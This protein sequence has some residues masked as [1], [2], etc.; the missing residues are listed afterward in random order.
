MSLRPMDT[1][2]KRLMTPSISLLV[3]AALTPEEHEV[4]IIDENIQEISHYDNAD[5]VGITCNVDTFERAKAHSIQF[6]NNGIPVILGGIFPSS[7]PEMAGQYADS[8]CI[9]DAEPL[10]Q[11][12]LNDAKRGELKKEYKWHN[13]YPAAMIPRPKW[14]AIEKEKYLYTNVITTSRGCPFSCEFCYNSC[15][16]MEKKYR[17][18]P[19]DSIIGEIIALG[20]SQVLF[21]DDNFI[22]DKQW[23]QDFL[24]RIKPLR[25]TWHAAV[26]ADI[27]NHLSILDSMK[28][29]GC[30]SLYIGFES[31]NSDSLAN[32]KKTQNLVHDYE[33]T[34][35]SIHS[36]DMMINAS[37]AF[38]FD[39]DYPDV[40][41]NSL[42][43]L[44]RNRIETMTSH[45]LT[46]YPGT[47]LYQRLANEGRI[48]D[49]NLN[50]YNTSKVVFATKNMTPEQLLNG[51]H[52][53]Y[54]DFYSVQ[55]ILKRRPKSNKQWVPYFL[56][57][58]GYRKY[59]KLTARIGTMGHMQ[60]I[61]KLARKL[62]YGIG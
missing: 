39:C 3:L 26:S 29:T 59:G 34:I 1:E 6:Q 58:L 21:V 22:G 23:L 14:E 25:L 19:L 61:G 36:R 11:T 28:E 18:R 45:I 57:N 42:E 52:K 17:R 47:K 4:E 55:N 2:L 62:S 32:V 46:P 10:W 31:I 24:I 40:F 48:I 44:I 56:F 60:L 41:A 53:I 49:N 38:G 8:V 5:L 12:I 50:N 20:T 7:S 30:K 27:G 9:G 37:M 16:Y 51:Y 13:G 54:D 15:K 35:D 33:K 43:W